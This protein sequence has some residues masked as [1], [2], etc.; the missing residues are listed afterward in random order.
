MDF[1]KSVEAP[2]DMT[3]T[4]S[5]IEMHN[6]T[7]NL[8]QLL[9]RVFGTEILQLEEAEI[10]PFTDE[11]VMMIRSNTRAGIRARNAFRVE[12]LEARTQEISHYEQMELI[13]AE[14]KKAG[15]SN[16]RNQ[17]SLKL[18]IS[19]SKAKAGA[20]TYI[21]NGKGDKTRECLNRMKEKYGI[22]M[23]ETLE[24]QCGVLSIVDAEH[25]NQRT[26]R[27]YTGVKD[28]ENARRLGK[29]IMDCIHYIENMIRIF[30]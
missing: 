7:N 29:N 17:Y 25:P 10:T 1:A 5:T 20:Y 2:P 13:K 11:E 12:V 26:T 19:V 14:K 24:G 21:L 22:M 4:T 18:S 27:D 30:C 16:K 3:S 6:T 8:E 28:T 15:T 23:E 9:Q